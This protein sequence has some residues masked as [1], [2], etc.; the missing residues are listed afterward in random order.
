LQA[1]N[2]TTS[3]SALASV[4]TDRFLRLYESHTVSEIANIVAPRLEAAEKK[5]LKSAIWR[6]LKLDPRYKSRPSGN[7]V[8]S[9][10]L[11]RPRPDLQSAGDW[12][13]VELLAAG[14]S[15]KEIL[16]RLGGSWP[17]IYLAFRKMGFPAGASPVYSFGE[18][19]DRSALRRL[20]ELSG[21]NVTELARQ[22]GVKFGTLEPHLSSRNAEKQ[23]SFE[24]ARRAHQWR[25]ALFRHLMSSGRYG[26]S[27]II[28]TFFPS[29]SINYKLLMDVLDRMVEANR[30]DLQWS[31]EGLKLYLCGQARKETAGVISGDLFRRFL[32]WAPV[33]LKPILVPEE[34][35]IHMTLENLRGVH[36]QRLAWDLIA[37]SLGTTAPVI[38]AVLNPSQARTAKAIFAQELRS[39]AVSVKIK[40]QGGRRVGMSTDSRED[41]DL[42]L[43]FQ[44]EF[45]SHHGTRKGSLIFAAKKV[46]GSTVNKGTATN[47]AKRLL[48]RFRKLH[49][50]QPLRL[51]S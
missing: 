15:R 9:A 38:S 51:A 35:S 46:Y 31:A 39:V 11:G 14:K 3:R 48:A 45:E 19:F 34:K 44:N 22:L 40:K 18:L 47:R 37:C 21:L 50:K 42:L 49:Q 6:R 23:V 1:Q 13:K 4:T 41:A 25:I 32:P 20:Q 29:L 43:T 17:G 33:I 16:A 2:I 30:N 27:R 10:K 5:R 7:A 24:V 26:Q 12:E 8:R 36:H 28:L